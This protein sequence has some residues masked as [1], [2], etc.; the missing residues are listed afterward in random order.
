MNKENASGEGNTIEEEKILQELSI[1]YLS[2]TPDGESVQ[3]WQLAVQDKLKN[4]CSKPP[5][6]APFR[7]KNVFLFGVAAA[8]LLG[9]FSHFLISKMSSENSFPHQN[10]AE[11]E[12]ESSTIHKTVLSM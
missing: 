7:S 5:N 3:K 4:Q 6:Q 8:F 2:V 12:S 9:F 1:S 11:D 10:I